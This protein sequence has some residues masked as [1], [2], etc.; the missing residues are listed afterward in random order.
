VDVLLIL[1]AGLLFGGAANAGVA[2]LVRRGDASLS[3]QDRSSVEAMAGQLA[4]YGVAIS[5]TLLVLA[6][7]RGL[8]VRELGWR[9]PTLRWLLAAVPLTLFGLAI[10]GVLAGVAESLLPHVPNEQCI[11]VQQQ[12]G[13]SVLL[14]LPV[15]CIAAPIVEETIFRGVLYRWLRGVLPLGTAMVVSAAVFALAHAVVLLFLPLLGLGIL[16]AWIYERA[17]SLWPGVLV[18]GLFNLAGIIDILTATKC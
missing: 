8:N 10:A 2:D 11:K 17:Q 5:V 4:F 9:R 3:A 6:G 16:L 1:L 18:H 15:V 14:A 12:Y 13:H 7:R